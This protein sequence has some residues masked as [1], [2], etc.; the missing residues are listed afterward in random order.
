MSWLSVHGYTAFIPLPLVRI[1]PTGLTPTNKGGVLRHPYGLHSWFLTMSTLPSLFWSSGT[2]IFQCDKSK[3]SAGRA[4]MAFGVFSVCVL[5][6]VFGV[7]VFELVQ[8]MRIIAS[9][10]VIKKFL[11]ILGSVDSVNFCRI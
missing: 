7:S 4:L 8:A 3:W 6:S 11:F 1:D 9:A 5:M 10:H 2:V